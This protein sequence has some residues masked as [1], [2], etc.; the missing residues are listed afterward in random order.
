MS[1][2]NKILYYRYNPH[3]ISVSYNYNKKKNKNNL[4]NVAVIGCGGG[5]MMHISHYL[6]HKNTYVKTVFDLHMNRFE[7]LQKRFP[8]AYNDIKKTNDLDDILKDDSIDIISIA[9][10]DHTHAFYA[11]K[12]L[13]AN[14]HVLVEKPMCTTMSDAK[15]IINAS[16]K[17][18]K[19]FSV[20][21]QMRFVPRNK[22]VKSMIDDGS[23][24][25]IFF[26]QTGYIHDMRDRA[27]KFSMWRKDPINFQHP[28]F[29]G[30]HNIDLLRWL[31]GD[32]IEINTVSSHKGFP[33]LPV[34]DTFILQLK[35][36]NGRIGNIITC[37]SPLVLR[38]HH[39]LRIYGTKGTVHGD[40]LF[41]KN[42]DVI[43]SKTLKDSKYKG[44]PQFRSQISA[45]VDAVINDNDRKLVSA[46]D[47]AKTVSVCLAAIKSLENGKPCFVEKI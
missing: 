2:L 46:E 41:F 16:N 9:T 3:M 33:D 1:I 21:Q 11:L 34:D 36:E 20:F 13:E 29:G 7:D 27:F 26:I 28:I 31:S 17:S 22:Y 47:G 42:K 6:W 40:K 24:G 32:I 18:N 12:A 14:K 4:L 35:L 15:K 10:P 30:Q 23:L 8:F 44:V 19:K 45:F 38:E 25:E 5:G 43:I 39:P 37:F